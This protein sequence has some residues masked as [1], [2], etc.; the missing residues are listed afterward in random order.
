VAEGDNDADVVGKV[1]AGAEELTARPGRQERREFAARACVGDEEA[2]DKEAQNADD[3]VGGEAGPADELNDAVGKD[4]AGK[5]ADGEKDRAEV[6]VART[7]FGLKEIGLGIGGQDGRT[8]V[9]PEIRVTAGLAIG[10][11]SNVAVSS[12]HS[13]C[14]HAHTWGELYWRL[15][16]SRV[17]SVCLETLYPY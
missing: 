7:R 11:L 15:R 2:G 3:F 4:P 16:V 6:G 1:E 13:A 17:P 8:G 10:I 9:G 12:P 5:A 14:E